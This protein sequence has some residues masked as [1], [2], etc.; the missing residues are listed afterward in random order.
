LSR[1]AP[2]PFFDLWS[3]SIVLYECL[4]AARPFAGKNAA[5]MLFNVTTVSAV[6]PSALRPECS[7][8]IDAFFARALQRQSN[9]RF[10]DAAAMQEALLR[11]RAGC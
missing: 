10:P 3:L 4:T 8:A 1:E 2:T 9:R 11:L 7:A 5:E 6:P